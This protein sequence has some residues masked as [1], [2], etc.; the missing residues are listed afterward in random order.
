MPLSLPSDLSLPCPSPQVSF[1]YF[2]TEAHYRSLAGRI[3]AALGGFSVVVVTGEPP[4]G[5][6]P[7]CAALGE[8]AGPRYRVVGFAGGRELG[9]HD[10]LRFCARLP[11]PEPS[12]LV[13][14]E[15]ER[16]SNEQ[17]EEVFKNLYPR[18]STGDQQSAV[19]VL[20]AGSKFLA[21]LKEPLLSVWLARRLL[22]AHLRL[23]EL[24]ADEIREFIRY[25]LGSNERCGAL[26]EEAIAAI[27]AVSGGDPAIIDRFSCRLLEAAGLMTRHR[28]SHA[29]DAVGP[30]A[31]TFAEQR[32]IGGPGPGWSRL[33]GAGEFDTLPGAW[34]RHGS[35]GPGKLWASLGFGVA[36][37][38]IVLLFLAQSPEEKIPPSTRPVGEAAPAISGAE[39][40]LD[41][42][43]LL[44][45]RPGTNTAPIP[46]WALEH[47]MASGSA[48]VA[49]G[50]PAGAATQKEPTLPAA[51]SLR[52]PIDGIAPS[53]STPS[54][55]QTRS[56][57][58]PVS[59]PEMDQTMPR[60][61][62]AEMDTL[63]ARGDE[64]LALGDVASARLF[65]ERA[66]RAGNRQAALKL[67]RAFDP[68][69][70]YRARFYNVRGNWDMA[71][72]WY[73]QAQ[74]LEEGAPR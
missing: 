70:I 16:L 53:F 73:H 58:G 15:T 20:L 36:C 47:A 4:A 3:L 45:D 27:A 39:L 59:K 62:A 71:A 68:I 54:S 55:I 46:R 56:N 13:I 30:A 63:L 65:Y 49:S 72:Y 12:L 51:V 22:V 61:S 66:A 25:R 18:T 41:S 44:R 37:T 31:P 42:M 32:A 43:T 48:E 35:S 28:F 38:S 6:N 29:A 17:I 67:A 23:H 64:M 11:V 33:S 9:R 10:L 60:L 34:G 21:R 50:A 7:L 57:A 19:V 1:D 24:G 74:M 69:V 26:T 8:L 5:A 14:E 52:L 40:P 2:L